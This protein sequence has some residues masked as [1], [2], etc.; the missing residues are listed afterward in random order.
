MG[1]SRLRTHVHPLAAPSA[2]CPRARA[3]VQANLG[4]FKVEIDA[5]AYLGLQ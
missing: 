4:E 2:R 5:I 3:T 1:E